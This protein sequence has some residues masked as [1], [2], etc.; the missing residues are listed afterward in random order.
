[1]DTVQIASRSEEGSGT[2]EVQ[3]KFRNLQKILKI[4][5]YSETTKERISVF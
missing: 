2:L 4:K 1:M 5:Y 3:V